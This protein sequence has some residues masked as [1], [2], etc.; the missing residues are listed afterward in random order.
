L[1]V[2]ILDE[3]YRFPPL[4]GG[5]RSLW[6]LQRSLA[7]LD[8]EAIVSEDAS[9]LEGARWDV[10]MVS[11]PMLA[12]R[13]ADRAS[14]AARSHTVYVGHDL[15]HR[16]VAADGG[17]LPGHPRPVAV[18][19]T[20]ERRCWSDYDIAIYP[21][22]A[23]VSVAR[24][25]GAH[26]RWFPYFRVDDVA[27]EQPEPEESAPSSQ[28]HPTTKQPATLLFVGGSAH[29]PN[30]T[31]LRWFADAVLR[32]L[33]S[34]KVVVVGQWDAAVRDPLAAEGLEFTGPLSDADLALLR[35]QVAAHI[36]PLT[37]GAGLKS[38]VI[39]AL[40]SGV[41]LIA[42][43][44]AMEGIPKPWRMALPADDVNQWRAALSAL[45]NPSAIAPLLANAA[46]YV[47]ARH[48]THAYLDAVQRL[49]VA[50]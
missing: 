36:A 23:E 33:P 21:N 34:V 41:P 29:A 9:L 46:A 39:D 6:D 8:H 2:L 22:D 11:R 13:V 35:A 3:A 38:K 47:H 19:A 1:T 27:A 49:L 30:V 17:T 16:R 10:V 26:A 31:G 24:D 37:A 45:R 44:V 4:D 20:L 32:H 7:D 5:A 14:R 18:L 40:A 15:H 12:A 25:S 42:T 28:A 43:S 48:G 50:P